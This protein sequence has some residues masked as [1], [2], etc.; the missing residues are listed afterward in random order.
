[1]TALFS[2][3]SMGRSPFSP[4]LAQASD[5]SNTRQKHRANPFNTDPKTKQTQEAG[6]NNPGI[7]SGAP[8][9]PLPLPRR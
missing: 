1:M 8:A 5:K 4:E 2:A 9:I 6:E 7:S 3:Q